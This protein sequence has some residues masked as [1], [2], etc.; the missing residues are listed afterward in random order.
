MRVYSHTHIYI[1]YI[2][3]IYVIC[4]T[5]VVVLWLYEKLLYDLLA[6]EV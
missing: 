5:K 3:I 2:Y 4:I 6:R 1:I